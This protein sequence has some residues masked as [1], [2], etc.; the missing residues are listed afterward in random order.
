VTPVTRPGVRR[1]SA[2][3]GRSSQEGT[4]GK[5][6]C[7]ISRFG[8]SPLLGRV[9][10]LVARGEIRAKVWSTDTIVA[11]EQRTLLQ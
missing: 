11:F 4:I 7:R 8:F 1:N 6:H 3:S 10:E 9:G 5:P 2:H